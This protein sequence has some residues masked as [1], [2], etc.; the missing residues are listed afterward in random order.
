LWPIGVIEQ[1]GPHLPTGTD[2]YIPTARARLVQAG[3]RQWSVEALVAPPYYWGINVVSGSFPASYGIRPDLMRE[4]L[5]DILGGFAADGFRQV[6]CFSGHGDALHN[7]TIH[8]AIALAAER[9][10]VDASFVVDHALAQRLGL[11]TEDPFLTLHGNPDASPVEGSSP[12]APR[13]ADASAPFIDV[14]AGRWET[15][16]MLHACPGL[17]REEVCRDLVP[18]DY[19]PADLAVWRQG[20]DAARE[21][22]PLGYFG[23]PASASVGE[24]EYSFERSAAEAVEAILRRRGR[25]RS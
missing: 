25:P 8:E 4:V 16:M 13:A 2:V 15:S 11:D 6:Y 24:G 21:K 18:T 19:G 22:T 1:H 17:V 10:Q 14:H 20:Y 23:D 9:S 12:S 3:L 5:A 7:R